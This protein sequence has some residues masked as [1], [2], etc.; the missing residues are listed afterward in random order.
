MITTLAPPRSPSAL[1]P[2]TVRAADRPLSLGQFL[3]RFVR[4]P[5]A[6]LPQAIYEAPMVVHDN[7]R[8]VVVWVADPAL[9]EEVLLSRADQFPKTPLEKQVFQHTLGD[10]ILTSQGAS[11]RWQR[12]TAA[13]LFRPA[14]L[15]N[16]VPIMSAAAEDQLLRWRG[17]GAGALRPIDRDMT[18]TTFRV[19][20][21]AMFAGSADAEAEQIL[22]S[23]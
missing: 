20:S 6:S 11:W 3:F 17:N 21:A 4:N 13:P 23:A 15:A 12:R 8:G 5:L 22:K 16:L 10:G 2:P 19:I 9:L 1:Y 14:E 18:E 7:G